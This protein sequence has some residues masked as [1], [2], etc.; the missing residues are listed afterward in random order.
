MSAAASW[1]IRGRTD[2]GVDHFARLL[3]GIW[4]GWCFC[5]GGDLELLA[6]EVEPMVE[7]AGR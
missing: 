1:A 7:E 5:A 4:P 3:S 6:T 2:T